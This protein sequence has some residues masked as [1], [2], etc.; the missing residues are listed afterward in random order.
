MGH[1]WPHI[2]WWL[3][4]VGVALAQRGVPAVI[5]N[6]PVGAYQPEQVESGL[7]DPLLKM[8]VETNPILAAKGAP[9]HSLG[10][11][12]HTAILEPFG[13]GQWPHTALLD[14][15]KVQPQQWPTAKQL[16]LA[17][18]DGHLPPYW[19]IRRV[20][21]L[22]L[23]ALEKGIIQRPD[24]IVVDVTETSPDTMQ[25]VEAKTPNVYKELK[26]E[27]GIPH[28]HISIRGYESLRNVY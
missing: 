24:E 23:R 13:V 6:L 7:F 1:D 25:D 15:A 14:A 12:E 8:L 18:W 19:H 5:G 17:R 22:I 10:V 4:S 21:W 26:A 28:P 11:H 27:H 16:P 2:V 9:P 3:T 20:D